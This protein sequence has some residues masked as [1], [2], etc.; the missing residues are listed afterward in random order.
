MLSRAESRDDTDGHFMCWGQTTWGTGVKAGR[1]RKKHSQESGV[2]GVSVE[3]RGQ[4]QSSPGPGE[5]TEEQGFQTPHLPQHW[6]GPRR[7][8]GWDPQQS[9]E[10]WSGRGLGGSEEEGKS[11]RDYP[12]ATTPSLCPLRD[13]QRRPKHSRGRRVTSTRWLHLAGHSMAGERG[14]GQRSGCDT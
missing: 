3:V 11:P 8:A 5:S 14:N 6:A 7:Q 2:G 12:P 1:S 9:Q 10:P 4:E 13:D